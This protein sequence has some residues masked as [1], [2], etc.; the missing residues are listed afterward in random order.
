MIMQ[1]SLRI[2]L[3]ML[4]AKG[5]IL[6][7]VSWT[8]HPGFDEGP[9][10]VHV[11]LGVHDEHHLVGVELEAASPGCRRSP[12]QAAGATPSGSAWPPPA[13]PASAGSAADS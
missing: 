2:S 1:L 8:H 13:A 3:N 5:G 6:S 7:S 11:V 10:A 12:R 9:P 4:H